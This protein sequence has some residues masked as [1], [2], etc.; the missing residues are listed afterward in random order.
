MTELEM[1]EALVVVGD[2]LVDTARKMRDEAVALR[3]HL[4]DEKYPVDLDAMLA[5]DGLP[6]FPKV[7]VS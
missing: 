6:P 1:A 5:A 4:Y 3:D 7:R 2:E